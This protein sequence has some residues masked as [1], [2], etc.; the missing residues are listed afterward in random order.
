MM[1]G[2]ASPPQLDLVIPTP[3]YRDGLFSHPIPSRLSEEEMHAADRL[4]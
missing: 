4:G 3:Y 1:G 2:F